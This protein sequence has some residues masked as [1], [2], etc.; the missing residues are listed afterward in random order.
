MLDQIYVSTAGGAA[1]GAALQQSARCGH[2]RPSRARPRPRR[3]GELDAARNAA[4]NALAASGGAR[5]SS[6][7]AV[8]TAQETMVPL[9]AVTH[10]ERGN[11]PLAVNHQGPFVTTTISFNLAAGEVARRRRR[12]NQRGR[13]GNPH[14]GLR[15]RRVPGTAQRFRQSSVA[16]MPLLILRGAWSRS[17]S[18]WACST[19]ATIHPMTILSTLPSAGVGALLGL[20]VFG[21]EFSIIALIGVI[22]LIGI[23]KKNAIMMIDFAIDAEREQATDAARRDLRGLPAAL[24][25]DH[26]DHHAPPCSAPCRWRSASA[27]AAKCAAARRRHRRRA[28]RQPD[29]DALHDAGG[30]SLSRPFQPVDERQ[31]AGVFAEGDGRRRLAA[32]YIDPR[33]GRPFDS[34]RLSRPSQKNHLR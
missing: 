19:R 27:R 16:S 21:I 17:I 22:L 28:D 18:C 11:A 25:P 14:A 3:V 2:G 33:F 13:G 12:R 30:L 29:A 20:M 24:P 6:G 1:N 7:A 9:S 23:V 32:E 10:F 4:T 5:A 8:S 15:P 26:D 34:P 31:A